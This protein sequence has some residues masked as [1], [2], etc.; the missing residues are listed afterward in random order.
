[1]SGAESSGFG[2]YVVVDRENRY[3][4]SRKEVDDHFDTAV[5]RSKRRN[6]TFCV[7]GC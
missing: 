3:R 7:N 6:E 4:E 1:M 5:T 2:G